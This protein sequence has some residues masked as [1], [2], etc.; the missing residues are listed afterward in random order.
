MIER[1]TE[2]VRNIRVQLS[3]GDARLWRNNVG[4]AWQGNCRNHGGGL[5]TIVH[6]RRVHFGLCQG[7]ADLIGYQSLIVTPE[8][9]GQRIAVF[10]A[11]EGKRVNGSYGTGQRE[12]LDLV[13]RAGGLAGVARTV[14]DAKIILGGT[15]PRTMSR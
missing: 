7:S 13:N 5:M 11:I 12:Y 10:V 14:D 9:V 8:M 6:P 2:T 15:W 3:H 1:E 4:S